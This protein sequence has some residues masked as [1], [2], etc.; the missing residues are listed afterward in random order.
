MFSV[1][2]HN[3]EV[4]SPGLTECEKSCLTTGPQSSIVDASQT[5][6]E[7]G[8]KHTIMNVSQFEKRAEAF[9]EE[10]IRE[11]YQ[12][13]AGL[14]EQLEIAPIHERYADLF[15]KDIVQTLLGQRQDK[16]GR[17]LAELARQMGYEGLDLEP[18]MEEFLYRNSGN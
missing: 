8:R 2:Q 13:L 6:L 16:Q 5:Q 17:Y 9:R 18:L 10:M 14:K 12:A 15:A 3:G 11:Y 7:E 1:S 4:N